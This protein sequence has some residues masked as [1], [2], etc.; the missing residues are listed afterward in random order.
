MSLL[1]TWNVACV[2]LEIRF[3]LY[4]I[5]INL[6]LNLASGFY[7][8]QHSLRPSANLVLATPQIYARSDNFYPFLLFHSAFYYEN[9]YNSIEI[10]QPTER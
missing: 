1:N 10:F 5:L 4:L 2:T 8:R 3:E 6:N 7:I 9:V